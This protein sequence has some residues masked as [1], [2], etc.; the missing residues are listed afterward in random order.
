MVRTSD[1]ERAIISMRTE[2][3]ELPGPE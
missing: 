1:L 2:L 3:A